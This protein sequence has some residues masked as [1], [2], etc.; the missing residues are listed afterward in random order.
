MPAMPVTVASLR[1]AAVGAGVEEVFE[2]AQLA[3]P[4]DERRLQAFDPL[5]TAAGGHHLQGAVQRQ[6]LGLS[7]EHVGPGRLVAHGGVGG[8]AR[9]LPDEHRARCRHRLDPARRVH[10]VARHQALAVGAEVDR[11]FTGEDPGT[12]A[13]VR[14][15]EVLPHRADRG[16]ELQGRAH[17]PLRVV[18]VGDRRTPDGHHRIADELLHDSAVADHDR[19]RQTSK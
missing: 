15:T 9:R 14:S 17:R 5:R 16:N 7:L 18:L 6:R 19:A 13:Q 1:G 8:T 3:V 11:R 4:A 12:Q 10:E 2:H